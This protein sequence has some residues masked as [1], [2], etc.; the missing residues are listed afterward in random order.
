MPQGSGKKYALISVV[1]IV[2]AL[3][4][5]TPKTDLLAINSVV[6]DPEVSRYPNSYWTQSTWNKGTGSYDYKFEDGM[7][8][9]RVDSDSWGG[10]G[11]F[12]GQK[13][14]GWGESTNVFNPVLVQN[15]LRVYW[16]GKPLSFRAVTLQSQTSL[17]VDFWFEV[18]GQNERKVAEIYVFFYQQGISSLPNQNFPIGSRRL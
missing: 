15:N 2:L 12:Q 4:V 11:V 13:P 14:F 7:L 17:G 18:E 1:L 8:T 3:I 10:V 6:A 9:M 16:R 5:L